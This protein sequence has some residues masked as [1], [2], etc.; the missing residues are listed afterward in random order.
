MNPR[1]RLD[2]IPS[3]LSEE[4][5][6][7]LFGHLEH[8]ALDFKRGVP[9]DIRDV[10]AAMAMTDGG[11]IVH[12]V[13]DDRQIVGCPLS[14]NTQ[15]RITR[16]AAECGVD[17]QLREVA[18]RVRT[19][20]TA[21]GQAS[22]PDGTLLTICAVPEVRG[23]I[24]TTPDGRLLR[25]V[26]GDSRPLR[27]DAMAR[28]VRERELRS[29]ED[30]PIARVSIDQFDLH[31]IN[32]ALQAEGRPRLDVD[33]A[34]GVATPSEEASVLRALSDLG[35]ATAAAPP[36]AT[37]VLWAAGVLFAVDP[38]HVLRGAAVQL[39]RRSGAGTG[40]GPT[41]ARGECVAPFAETVQC[42]LEFIAEHTGR[43]EVVA[44]VR[45]ET[46]PAYPVAVLREAVVNAL[47][48][49]DYSLSGA[50][51]D[52]TVWDDR[53]EVRSPG[54]LPGHITQENMRD[55]HYSRNP[56]I[57]RVLKSL[58]LVEE[59]GE[60]IDRMYREMEARLLAPPVFEAT[61][62]SV[63]VT[64]RHRSLVDVEDQAWLL[65]LANTTTASERLALIAARRDGAVTRRALRSMMTEAQADTALKGAV[66]KG[67]LRR[68]GTAGGTRY[69][70]GGAVGGDAGGEN[71]SRSRLLEEAR[72][73]GAI[74]SADAARL[75]QT[76]TETAR[77]LLRE[78]VRDGALHAEGNTRGRKYR[79]TY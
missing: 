52:I 47:A 17:V 35:V 56:R 29:G 71:R 66:A 78:L 31:A 38:R 65:G 8:E 53:V 28:F 13:A 61:S 19:P 5:F 26:G 72:R 79:P 43:A 15:D 44:G 11:L 55:E 67:L 6:W 48:H 30:E 27:G 73:H 59:Y 3:S 64:L 70:L 16:I 60:G 63:T 54:P 40:P 7:H 77:K 14:Q 36:L 25:R 69:V 20:A 32:A 10:I 50:T 24:V 22:P 21:P 76:S 41:V 12:G 37:R 39:A 18:I 34:A 45:R 4:E 23:R 1:P 9:T 49:R 62:S 51:V 42:C 57:M 33:A 68:V 74:T 75:L 46:L 58:G 2:A